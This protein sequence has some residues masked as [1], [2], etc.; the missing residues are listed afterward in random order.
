[1][2]H[3]RHKPWSSCQLLAVEIQVD[4][5]KHEH[6]Q[7]EGKQVDGM[8]HEHVQILLKMALPG[9]VLVGGVE[10]AGQS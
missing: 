4:G 9:M 8:K 3:A 10:S 6:V 7:V 1:M 5:M 2:N